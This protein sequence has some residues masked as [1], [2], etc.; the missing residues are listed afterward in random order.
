MRA[1]RHRVDAYD[2]QRP[3]HDQGGLCDVDCRPVLRPGRL[4]PSSLSRAVRLITKS[5]PSLTNATEPDKHSTNRY[6]VC[7]VPP[8]GG[9]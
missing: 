5:R 1:C 2:L 7:A 6:A 8:L 9:A 3:V 4:D